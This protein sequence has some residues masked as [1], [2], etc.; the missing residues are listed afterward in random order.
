M[1]KMGKLWGSVNWQSCGR[2]QYKNVIKNKINATQRIHES[3]VHIGNV[4]QQNM[5]VAITANNSETQLIQYY[6]LNYFTALK[7]K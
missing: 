3:T 6:C 2:G 1:Y 5:N 4:R 7:N